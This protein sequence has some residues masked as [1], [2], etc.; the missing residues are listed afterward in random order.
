VCFVRSIWDPRLV[1]DPIHFP[2]LA[3]VVG[4]GLFEV[5]RVGVQIRPG[6]ANENDFSVEIVLGV[7]LAVSIFELADLGRSYFSILAV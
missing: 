6:V 1:R 5:G 3:A 7:E 4:E 2:G